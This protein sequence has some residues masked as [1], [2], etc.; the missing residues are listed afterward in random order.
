MIGDWWLDLFL[1]D[2]TLLVVVVVVIDLETNRRR[3]I[4][5]E[6]D[7]DEDEVISLAWSHVSEHACFRSD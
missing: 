1:V 4:D 5:Y 3:R 6:D 7:D 2:L